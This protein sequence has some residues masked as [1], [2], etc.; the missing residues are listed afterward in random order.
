MHKA[1]IALMGMV[2]VL[3]SS[4]CAFAQFEYLLLQIIQQ[5]Q[6]STSTTSTAPVGGGSAPGYNADWN[7]LKPQ[8]S[9]ADVLLSY[10]QKNFTYDSK[11]GNS[12]P[13]TL[14]PAQTNSARGGSCADYSAFTSSVLMADGY[15][16]VQEISYMWAP[17]QGHVVTMYLDGGV[18][19]II[20]N[21]QYVGYATDQSSLRA[22]LAKAVGTDPSRIG[23]NIHYLPAEWLGGFDNNYKAP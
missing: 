21:G 8:L 18:D 5:Q 3:L 19:K 23:N 16:D 14:T 1:L 4:T 9:T 22:V 2:M 12:Q 7:A 11:A 15:K 17:G 6:A 13:Q 10:E 20:S